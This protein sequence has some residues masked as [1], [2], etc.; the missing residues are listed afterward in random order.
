[1]R[2]LNTFNHSLRQVYLTFKRL[3]DVFWTHES[4]ESWMA[5]RSF[6]FM[7][8]RVM[9]ENINNIFQVKFRTV[10]F[11]FIRSHF[12]ISFCAFAGPFLPVNTLPT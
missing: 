8:I 2:S 3:T 6:C 10:S 1:M 7:F 5:S 9:A 4:L 11:V 12:I